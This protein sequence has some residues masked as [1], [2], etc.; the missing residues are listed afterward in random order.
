[1]STKKWYGICGESLEEV[2]CF[3]S[4]LPSQFNHDFLEFCE[5][6][7]Q[8]FKAFWIRRSKSL[9]KQLEKAKKL[10]NLY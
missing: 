3:G 8:A 5:T 9:E 10:S 2:K 4:E 1:M 6:P 7:Q